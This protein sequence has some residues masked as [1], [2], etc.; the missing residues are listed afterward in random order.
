MVVAVAAGTAE[1]AGKCGGPT[2]RPCVKY[3]SQ[4]QSFRDLILF[5]VTNING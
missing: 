3:G 5:V 4:Y 2:S 1:A